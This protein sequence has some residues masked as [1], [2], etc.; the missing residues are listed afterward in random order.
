[1][2]VFISIIFDFLFLN[3][4]NDLI[5]YEFLVDNLLFRY[6]DYIGVQLI[7]VRVDVSGCY[8]AVLH[9]HGI[10]FYLSFIGS[11]K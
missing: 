2:M 8:I 3:V 10:I 1:M 11:G 4:I 6:E 7:I 9:P 5:S